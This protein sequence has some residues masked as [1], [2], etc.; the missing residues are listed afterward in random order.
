MSE[1]SRRSFLK[2]SALAGLGTSLLSPKLLAQSSVMKPSAKKKVI[3]AG[4]GIAGLCT[5]YELMKRGHEVTV[6]EA[7][8]RHEIGRAHV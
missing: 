6:L 7:T 1:N 8:G 2:K 4:A 3:V 5:A